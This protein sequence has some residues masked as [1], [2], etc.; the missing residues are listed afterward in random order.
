MQPTTR[1]AFTLIELL[2]VIAIIALLIGILLPALG[3]ARTA[4]RDLKCV[5]N[6]KTVVGVMNMYSQV[7]SKGWFNPGVSIY[8]DSFMWIYD[9]EYLSES[10]IEVVICPLTKNS[11]GPKTATRRW[12]PGQGWV[13]TFNWPGMLRSARSRHDDG[14]TT[15]TVGHSYEIWTYYAMG[16]HVDGRQFSNTPIVDPD[17]GQVTGWADGV[18]MTAHN[19]QFP[20]N[21]YLLLDEDED[22]NTATTNNNWPDDATNNHGGRG[23]VLGF[24][25]GHAEFAD[26]HRYVEASLY[27]PHTYFG[28]G[29]TCEEL[30]QTEFPNVRNT[31]GW[32]GRW[33]FED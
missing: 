25:D 11:V 12:V 9:A 10:E 32:F 19:S 31:G 8:D 28:N 27:S 16:T 17:T 23:L 15:A 21:E 30:A 33:W 29:D 4:A 7:N 2:V 14:S 3:K 13:E 1:R 20:S 26:K 22:G 24:V 5:T 18:R 6:L